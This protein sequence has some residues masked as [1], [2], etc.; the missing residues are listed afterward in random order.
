MFSLE[1]KIAVITGGGAGLGRAAAMRFARA[2]AKVVVANRSDASRLA[3]EIGGL[4]VKTDVSQEDQMRRLMEKTVAAFGRL[5]IVVNNAGIFIDTHR[6]EDIRAADL[7]ATLDVNLKG[8]V[9]GIKYGA[10]RMADGGSIVNIASIAGYQGVAGYGNYVMSK[11]G[12]IGVTK[13][14][15][16]DLAPRGIR[17]NCICPS[18]IDAGMLDNIDRLDEKMRAALTIEA[19]RSKLLSPL[20][21]LGTAED[22]A[23]L[24]HFLASD[25][26]AFITGTVIPLD[27][28]RTAGV[29]QALI[30]TLADAALSQK[31]SNQ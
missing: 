17:V 7:E 22:F 27:G 31:V 19:A 13:A 8:V 26:S 21:R 14:A 5:D 11:A 12:V 28:G 16:M 4:Y 1:G 24:G 10:R 9:W 30:T 20:G 23:A 2:G 6:V 29:S 25:D 15:A 3:A 18:S